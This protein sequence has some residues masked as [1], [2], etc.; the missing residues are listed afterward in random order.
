[1]IQTTDTGQRLLWDLGLPPARPKTNPRHRNVRKIR[2]TSRT[3]AASLT[4][5]RLTGRRR[6]IYQHILRCGLLGATD[7][8]AQGALGLSSQQ[9]AP[10]RGELATHGLI[11]DSGERRDTPSGRAAVVWVASEVMGG[12]RP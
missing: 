4:P 3:A 11:L 9:L 1:M 7:S 6:V 12:P 5:E 2:A 10:R 8:E